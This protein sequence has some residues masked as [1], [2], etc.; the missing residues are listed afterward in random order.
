MSLQ[1]QNE[2]NLRQVQQYQQAK[3]LLNRARQLRTEAAA[4]LP[5]LRDACFPPHDFYDPYTRIDKLDDSFRRTNGAVIFERTKNYLALLAAHNLF[6]RG[7]IREQVIVRVINGQIVNIQLIG[8]YFSGLQQ[9]IQQLKDLA[10]LLFVNAAFPETG[11]SLDFYFP[12]DSNAVFDAENIQQVAHL[13][14]S[15]EEINLVQN[16]GKLFVNSTKVMTNEEILELKYEQ[17]ES[18]RS[19]L[20]I[21]LARFCNQHQAIGG[22]DLLPEWLNDYVKYDNPIP[23]PAEFTNQ[24]NCTEQLQRLRM[25]LGM[26]PTNDIKMQ[27]LDNEKLPKEIKKV[28]NQMP[29][30]YQNKITQLA[31]LAD[32]FKIG[33][34]SDDGVVIQCNP[35]IQDLK[36][37]CQLYK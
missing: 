12:A 20:W 29:V 24:C 6:P 17:M 1:A 8:R 32:S 21:V 34:M 15:V 13:V 26:Y 3:E 25:M 19:E 4:S 28:L 16:P 5:C 10:A 35:D 2:E 37:L 31:Y 18:N 27:D 30:W 9:P 7:D 36:K 11:N 22:I 33:N 14:T 23:L